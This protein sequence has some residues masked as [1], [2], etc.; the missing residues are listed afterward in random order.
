[1]GHGA[2]IA[3][4]ITIVLKF[5]LCKFFKK[6]N[7]AGLTHVMSNNS[8][9]SPMPH[10]PCKKTNYLKNSPTNNYKMII[11]THCHIYLEEFD[12][13]FNETV[14]RAK[15]NGISGI[16]LPN[17]DSESVDKM[18]SAFNKYPDFFHRT[19]GLHPTSVDKDFRNQLEK[20]FARDINIIGVGETGIDLYWDKTYFNEQ[21]ESFAF[22]LDYA[23]GKDLPIIIHSRNSLNEVIDIV[24]LFVP[25][26]IRGVFHCYPGNAD[27][28]KQIVDMGFYLGIGGVLTYKNNNMTDVVK[29]I[30]CEYLLTETDAPYLTPVPLRG[31]RNEPAYITNVVSK[32]SEL[33]NMSFNK[34]ASVTAENARKLFGIK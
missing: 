28:A 22:Q 20:I 26:G 15:D 16:V 11:D 30:P 17:I 9:F 21:Q 10:A 24:K 8:T 23:C 19:L 3:K 32:I 12:N 1:M 27:E 31:K 5:T 14:Q 29:K 33:K 4:G 7:P 34:V 25:K 6:Q 13:D 18:E 2:H